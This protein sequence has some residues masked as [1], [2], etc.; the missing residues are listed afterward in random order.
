MAPAR[1]QANG[2]ARTSFNEQPAPQL[3]GYPVWHDA[4]DQA[5]SS[6]S[7][8]SPQNVNFESTIAPGQEIQVANPHTRTYQACDECRRRKIKCD[9][10]P[11]DNPHAPPCARCRR[12]N[13][14][15][16][17]APTR[18][19]KRKA[20]GEEDEDDVPEVVTKRQSLV[21][22]ASPLVATEEEDHSISVLQTHDINSGYDSLNMLISAAEGLSKESESVTIS[23]VELSSQ[24][25]AWDRL[26][27]VRRGWFTAKEGIQYID[28]FYK[29]LLP[30]TPLSLSLPESYN[31]PAH[32]IELL[33]QEPF[34]LV[35][36]LTISSRYMKLSGTAASSRQSAIHDKLW[37]HLR[38]MVERT[39]WAQEQFGGGLCGAG[40]KSKDF[41]GL[42]TD[43]TIEGFLLLT[44]WHPRALHFP[45]S[46]DDDLMAPVMSDVMDTDSESTLLLNGTG[47]QRRDSWLE[48]CWRS[49]RMCWML[50]GHAISL[51]F[52]T[53]VFE[54]TVK[55]AS[56]RR[57]RLR[58]LIS[59]YFIL[60]SG[61][62][63]LIG[64]LPKGYLESLSD[65]LDN[66]VPV[67]LDPMLPGDQ[68]NG[69]SSRDRAKDKEIY[70]WQ[71]F[72]QIM[73]EGNE[74]FFANNQETRLLVRSGRYSSILRE[75][76]MPKM[77]KWK[78]ELKLSGLSLMS[79]AVLTV[80]YEYCLVYVNSLAMQAVV[81]RCTNNSPAPRSRLSRNGHAIPPS[82]FKDF[83]HDDDR[84]HIAA[85]THGC[86]KI[87]K[88]VTDE[89]KNT[90]LRH[91]SVRTYFRIVATAVILLKTFAL[92][93]PETDVQV[94]LNLFDRLI[95]AFRANIVDDV[96]VGNR[97]AD[98][99]ETLVKRIRSRLVRMSTTNGTG[100]NSRGESPGFLGTPVDIAMGP[101]RNIGTPFQA[102]R[103]SSTGLLSPESLFHNMPPI[104]AEMYDP[105]SHSMM[106]PPAMTFDEAGQFTDMPNFDP[107]V[108]DNTDW[109]GLPID[110]LFNIGAAPIE[111]TSLGPSVGGF[112][113]LD[114]LLRQ[115]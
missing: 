87:L 7:E 5:E 58:R 11:V 46:N 21:V 78:N 86:Q 30:L 83:Y 43:G 64:K 113:M 10:G 59:T 60:L 33:E 4:P 2:N 79:R 95:P 31:V 77:E 99:C 75:K 38:G 35:V 98:M 63:E 54:G 80:E 53:G 69:V 82:R 73:K 96:H 17:F 15:C 8:D 112:D 44:E 91:C 41:Q 12:E 1:N 3:Y 23:S 24:I 65:D 29:Y 114:V 103:G 105:M 6:E 36:M 104:S 13:R 55:P 50:L 89:T 48:P 74:E 32:Q 85:L 61:R 52:E 16:T 67:P 26:Q 62:L 88:I 109:I 47:G 92:G 100:Q 9:M 51:A 72:A 56:S 106:P 93:A 19:K 107:S 108:M 76:Y 97:F 66:S 42:R 115:T 18:R 57:N 14:D 40:P 84:K 102:S 39:L 90:L 37:I 70:L 22:Q 110:N 101:P 111:T 81:E 20:K 25:A 34:L 28:Y 68:L 49:D 27:F 71:T 94:S 45:P